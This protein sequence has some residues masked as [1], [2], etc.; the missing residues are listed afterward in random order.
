MTIGTLRV[1]FFAASTAAVPDTAMTSGR[2][3]RRSWHTASMNSV[4]ALRRLV[5]HF[6]RLPRHVAEF[7][8]TVQ[9]RLALARRRIGDRREQQVADARLPGALREQRLRGE[10][11]S[12]SEGE[13]RAALHAFSACGAGRAG[14]G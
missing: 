8:Q 13:Q 9:E 4:L 3:P 1:A 6:H 11:R 7:A 2:W 5:E 10:R 14:R 12:G